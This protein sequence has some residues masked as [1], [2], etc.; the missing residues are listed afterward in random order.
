MTDPGRTRAKLAA[1]PVGKGA[2][3]ARDILAES[4][5][6]EVE[7]LLNRGHALLYRWATWL[8]LPPSFSGP[9]RCAPQQSL[10]WLGLGLA[11][12]MQNRYADAEAAFRE[13]L[14]RTGKLSRGDEPGHGTR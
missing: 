6:D 3:A 11:R 2:R 14:P 13:A 4:K 5:S 12:S 8:L 1:M 7:V 10:S 9:P